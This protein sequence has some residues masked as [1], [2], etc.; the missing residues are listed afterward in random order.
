MPAVERSALRRSRSAIGRGAAIVA[1]L[2]ALSLWM[3]GTSTSFAED[4]SIELGLRPIDPAGNFFELTL[5]PGETRTLQVELANLGDVAIS[6]RTYAAD[7]YTIVNG[8][9]G[10]RLRDEPRTGATL[11]LDYASEVVQLEPGQ[12]IQRAFTVTVPTDAEAG[13]HASSI[14]L[15]NEEPLRGSGEVAIDQVIRQATAVVVTVPGPQHPA[16]QIGGASHSVVADKSVVAVAVENPGN[17]RLRPVADFAL[18]DAAHAEVSRATVPM[19]SF[20]AHTSTLVEVPLAALLQPGAYTVDLALEDVE[21]G[22]RVE[23]LAIPLLIG[24]PSQPVVPTGEPP[25]LTEVIQAARENSLLIVIAIL[26]AGILGAIF[27]G[28][29]IVRRRRANRSP[30]P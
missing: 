14:I 6:A 18:F 7:V 1:A 11:W 8:G 30:Q 25:G 17:I 26:V 15:E 21:H 19:D 24:P 28:W 9:F 4:G 22:V 29:L 10:A 5:A 16:L 2:L 12:G 13:E 27:V 20:Y 23:E 3:A